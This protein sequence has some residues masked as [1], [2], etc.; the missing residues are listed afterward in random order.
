MTLQYVF[1]Q[2]GDAKAL[3]ATGSNLT[4]TTD[5]TAANDSTQG[6]GIGSVWINTTIWRVWECMS[7]AVG[8]AVWSFSGSAYSNGG[9]NPAAEVTQF[10]LGAALMGEEGNIARQISA[11][12]ISPAATGSDYVLA[13]YSMPANSFDVAGRGVNLLS[14]GSFGATA[15]N[16]R[17][18]LIF[19]ATTAVVGSVVT[20]GITVC[21]TG[22]VATNAN[23]WCLEANVFKYGATGSNTQIGIHQSAQTGN[24]VSA[25]LAPTLIT[26]AENAPI[27]IAV[28]G[29]ATTAANDIVFSFLEVNAMN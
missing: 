18:K 16:K 20:G 5:P 17:L 8:A 2:N 27:L 10:G 4:A 22:V 19:N 28:T 3:L 15:N 13:V 25:L 11:A 21:D 29:N 24:T 12:G 9:S 23:G 7:A 1:T 14:M 6:Y 26:A